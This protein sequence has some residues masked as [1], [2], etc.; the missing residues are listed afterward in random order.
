MGETC[1]PN[2]TVPEC[3][4]LGGVFRGNGTTCAS[5]T[6]T[7]Q[8]DGDCEDLYLCTADFCEA[9]ICV[10]QPL[11]Y[12]DVNHDGFVNVVD[13]LC[14]LDTFAGIPFSASC[15]DGGIS[16]NPPVS[17]QRKDIGPCPLGDPHNMGDGFIG[18]SD[19]LAVLDTF[20]GNLTAPT[21]ECAAQ[22]P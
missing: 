16:G 15:A 6:C 14:H 4:A 8:T 9:G 18:A 22:C 2:L 5:V 12:A 19:V 13:M 1:T 7:C 20:G 10:S 11:K 21:A 3:E 17:F